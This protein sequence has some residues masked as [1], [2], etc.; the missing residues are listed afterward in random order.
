MIARTDTEKRRKRYAMHRLSLAM[1][2]LMNAEGATE[3]MMA[4]RWV[5]AWSGAVGER[6][7][8]RT[9]YGSLENAAM[10]RPEFRGH[11]GRPS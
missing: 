8:A 9:A 3:R 1:K 5:N 2:R 10:A 7:F 11:G 6:W 4:R